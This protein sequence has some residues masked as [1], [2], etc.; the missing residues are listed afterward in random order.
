M[1]VRTRARESGHTTC[2]CQ[3]NCTRAERGHTPDYQQQYLLTTILHVRLLISNDF[4]TAAITANVSKRL[5]GYTFK[6]TN[7]RYNHVH[8]F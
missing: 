8:T 7:W 6:G 4:L 2:Y 5:N 3:W 1:R